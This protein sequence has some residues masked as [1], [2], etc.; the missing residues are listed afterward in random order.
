[1]AQNIEGLLTLLGSQVLDMD[2]SFIDAS[3]VVAKDLKHMHQLL[4]LLMDVVLLI[5]E[6]QEEEEEEAEA[7]PKAALKKQLD[8]DKKS[9][10]KKADRGAAPAQDDQDHDA[11]EME[12]SLGIGAEVDEMSPGDAQLEMPDEV[13]PDKPDL[14]DGDDDFM[15]GMPGESAKKEP[16]KKEHEPIDLFNEPLIP[17][18]VKPAHQKGSGKK[19]GRSGSFG[20]DDKGGFDDELDVAYDDLNDDEKQYLLEQLWEEY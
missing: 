1:M 14:L 16:K 5:A 12:R 9:D 18:D 2:L 7:D 3:K 19:R 11:K 13:E 6:R 20:G 10:S 8:S 17:E 4:Q 15:A